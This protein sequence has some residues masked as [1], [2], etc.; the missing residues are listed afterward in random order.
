M[1]EVGI[2]LVKYTVPPEAAVAFFAPPTTKRNKKSTPAKVVF[3]ETFWLLGLFGI[4]KKKSKHFKGEF[5]HFLCHKLEVFP[6]GW[7]FRWKT[8]G[9]AA[10]PGPSAS[11]FRGVAVIGFCERVMVSSA[12]NHGGETTHPVLPQHPARVPPEALKARRKSEIR[13]K[14]ALPA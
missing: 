12:S 10:A 8:G 3:I 9:T 5:K 7:D 4:A 2:R 6:F 1:P 11:F 14:G 13:K